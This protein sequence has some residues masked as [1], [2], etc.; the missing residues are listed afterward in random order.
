M[1]SQI[2]SL[3]A[4]TEIPMPESSK[5]HKGDYWFPES[6]SSFAPEVDFLYYAIFW[7]STVFFI[8]IISFMC[9]FCWKYRRVGGVN[10]EI[11]VEK[12]PSHNTALEIFWSVIPSVI[13]VWIFWVGAKGFFEMRVPTADVEE[14]RVKAQKWNWSFTYPNGDST[15]ELHL[16]LDKPVKLVMESPDVLHSFFVP[17]FRQKMDIVPGRYTYAYINPTR[18]GEY[19]L[20]C[21]EYCG[22]GHSRM[23]TTCVVHIDEEDRKE[24]TKWIRAEH[25][26]W[27]NGERLYKMHCSGCHRIDGQAAT[28]PALNSIWGEMENLAG[29]KTRLVDETYVKESIYT[30]GAELVAGYTNQMQVFSGKLNDDDVAD[31]IAYLKFLKDPA[32]FATDPSVFG[33]EKKED[34]GASDSTGSVDDGGEET[35]EGD[36]TDGAGDDGDADQNQAEA[37]NG[38]GDEN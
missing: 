32:K 29:G 15:T 25:P 27:E 16:V 3:L 36:D 19:R 1:F 2:T 5:V 13:L 28:G 31:I 37:D 34:G 10:G 35:G 33:G 21:T 4:Q 6:A 17:A 12:S 8:L 30:P 26:P 11:K 7:I 20:S 9:Y 23:R 14:I 22:D 18:V 24:T 38:N